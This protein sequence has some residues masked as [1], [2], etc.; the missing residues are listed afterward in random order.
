MLGY[1]PLTDQ[2]LSQIG[3][4]VSKRGIPL[5]KD[6]TI[7][8]YRFVI[9]KK[10]QIEAA[11]GHCGQC[12]TRVMPDGTLLKGAQGNIPG[13][14][15]FAEDARA[16]IRGPVEAVRALERSLFGGPPSLRSDPL[17]NLDKMSIDEIASIHEVIPPGVMA[18][19][20]TSPFL[21]VQVPDLIGVKDRKYLDRTGL[22]RHRSIADL[23]RYAALNQGIDSLASYNGFIPL[24][25][26]RFDKLPEPE[27]SGVQRYSDEQ[28]Y[29][30]A[31]YLYSL[32]PPVN[33]NQWNASAARGRR[34][35]QRNGCPTCHTPPL[36]TNNKLTVAKGFVVPEQH[37]AV[38]DILP[39]VVGTDPRLTMETLR[40]TG[41]YKVPALKGLWYRGM[42][43]HSGSVATLEDWF[44]ARRLRDDYVPTGFKGYGVKT[45]AVKGHEFGLEL[46]SGDKAALIA[47]LRTL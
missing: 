5:A 8:F 39:V 37:R 14:R 46:S 25:G 38:Y 3:E 24:G 26:A 27:K 35:F 7:P 20:R 11:A 1:F 6:G 44:D 36:Y 22:Q 15:T 29:A 23:M 33:S 45:R 16:G 9:R 21:P 43:E 41:Y 19:H 13:D 40:G 17:P 34:V 28:L 30:L 47:F 31:L 18:R 12:H 10:G 2:G 32:E 42:F 4:Y